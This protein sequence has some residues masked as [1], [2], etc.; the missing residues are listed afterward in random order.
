MPTHEELPPDVLMAPRID[1]RTGRP[2][3]EWE[4]QTDADRRLVKVRE[5]E[6]WVDAISVPPP[7]SPEPSAGRDLAHG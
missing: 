1:P 7:G 6:A 2:V 5:R 3:G 4:P